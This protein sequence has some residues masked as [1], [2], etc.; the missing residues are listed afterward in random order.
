MY[1]LIYFSLLTIINYKQNIAFSYPQ[2][3]RN[4]YYISIIILCLYV[5]AACIQYF[6]EQISKFYRY[7]NVIVYIVFIISSIII[8]KGVKSSIILVLIFVF[9]INVILN[10]I[11]VDQLKYRKYSKLMYLMF[12]YVGLRIVSLV[13]IYLNKSVIMICFVIISVLCQIMF[14]LLITINDIKKIKYI[15]NN[16]TK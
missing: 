1:P 14:C 6:K 4:C 15:F 9:I 3:S 10:L 12:L 13:V 7:N 2:I 11:I 5:I 8:I 16:T